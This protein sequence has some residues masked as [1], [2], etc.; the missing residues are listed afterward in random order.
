M[1]KVGIIFLILLWVCSVVYAQTESP[2]IAMIIASKD[3]RDEELLVPKSIF[4]N[5]GFKVAVVADSKGKAKGMLGAVVNV[6]S[7]ID[8]LNPA[9]YKAVIFVGGVGASR[10]WK[11]QTAQNI[12]RD[13]LANN[14]VLGAICIAPVILANAGVLDGRRATV[15][16]SEKQRLISCG[17]RYTGASVEV[18]GNIVTGS[19]PQAAEEFTEAILELIK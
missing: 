7:T 12:A 16:P 19:G 4:E 15:W 14:R 1:R 6:D 18:D 10:F 3:F 8:E 2:E 5:A 11:N 9:D 13:T 17:A